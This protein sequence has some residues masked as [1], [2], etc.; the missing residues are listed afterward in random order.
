MIKV[1]QLHNILYYSSIELEKTN[2]FNL[3]NNS[4]CLPQGSPLEYENELDCRRIKEKNATTNQ[5]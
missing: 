3:I 1:D 5:M 4:F 2:N